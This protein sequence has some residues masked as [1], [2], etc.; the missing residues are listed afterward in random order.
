MFLQGP[1]PHRPP[2]SSEAHERERPAGGSLRRGDPASGEGF[3]ICGDSRR[4]LPSQ[5]DSTLS[6]GEH[7]LQQIPIQVNM[8]DTDPFYNFK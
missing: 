8:D 7:N 1:V 2:G 6:N 3:P 4:S 5:L